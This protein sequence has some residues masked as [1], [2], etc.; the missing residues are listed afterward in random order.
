[1][2]LT[3]AAGG[4]ATLELWDFSG[5]GVALL[6]VSTAPSYAPFLDGI[7]LVDLNNNV[8]GPGA[9]VPV[10]VVAGKGQVTFGLPLGFA[11]MTFYCQAAMTDPLL[12]SGF[13]LT[14]GLEVTVCN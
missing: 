1:M 3:P 10:G 14:N 9:Y 2:P 11:G 7:V 12:P 13:A 8:F 4:K 5:N 6:L